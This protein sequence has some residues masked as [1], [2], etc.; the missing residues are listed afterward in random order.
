MSATLLRIEFPDDETLIPVPTQYNDD[1]PAHVKGSIYWNPTDRCYCI[2]QEGESVHVE[3]INDVWHAVLRHHEILKSCPA[4]RLNEAAGA[5]WWHESDAQ[6]LN[7]RALNAIREDSEDNGSTGEPEPMTPMST[8]SY[9]EPPANTPMTHLAEQVDAIT[10]EPEPIQV[11][12]TMTEAPMAVA[13]LAI[14]GGG[15]LPPIVDQG[16]VLNQGG[17]PPTGLP[18]GLPQGPPQGPPQG[19]PHRGGPP[20]W[21]PAGPPGGGPPGGGLP[22]GPMPGPGYLMGV[23]TG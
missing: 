22:Q 10:I 15:P 2:A 21:P 13:N 12:A 16:W 9:Q 20:G 17:A 18:Q 6:H 3:F 11:R 14:R 8:H 5:G 23:P 7:N 19:L 4:F 1:L